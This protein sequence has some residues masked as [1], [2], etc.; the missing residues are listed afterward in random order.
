M[1]EVEEIFELEVVAE[2]SAIVPQLQ[3]DFLTPI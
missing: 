3:R 1:R 2:R